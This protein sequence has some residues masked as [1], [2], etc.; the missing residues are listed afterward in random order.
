MLILIAL[1]VVLID[2]AVYALC[3]RIDPPQI[4]RN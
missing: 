2:S 1:A 3:L 4:R